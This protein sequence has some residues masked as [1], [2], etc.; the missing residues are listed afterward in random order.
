M[1]IGFW[2]NFDIPVQNKVSYITYR[3]PFLR[4][5]SVGFLSF[6]YFC[7]EGDVEV[8]QLFL[9]GVK[10]TQIFFEGTLGCNFITFDLP[11]QCQG[12]RGG[13][14]GSGGREMKKGMT[15]LL[16]IHVFNTDASHLHWI[17]YTFK[18]H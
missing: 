13:T 7:G 6:E 17:E 9:E 5:C 4:V 16:F 14:K 10:T 18:S 15:L 3:L 11:Y 2:T 8:D 12:R 1:K